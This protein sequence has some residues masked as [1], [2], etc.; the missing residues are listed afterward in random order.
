RRSTNA[1]DAKHRITVM[2]A[3]R[4]RCC[5]A[6]SR[7]SAEPVALAVARARAALHPR[8][9]PAFAPRQ[10]QSARQALH[11]GAVSPRG[12]KLPAF[13]RQFGGYT[14]QACAL[15]SRRRQHHALPPAG[16]QRICAR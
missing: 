5:P 7:V 6:L 1:N 13:P 3:A 9:I 4:T 14:P 16:P 11:G 12:A 8:R 15:V 2:L 10:S